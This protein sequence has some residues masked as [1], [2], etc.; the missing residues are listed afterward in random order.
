MKTRKEIYQKITEK[1]QPLKDNDTIKYIDLN[2]GQLQSPEKSFPFGFPCVLIQIDAIR[3]SHMVEDRVEGEAT[4]TLLIAYRH[5]FD[6]F[7]GSPSKSSSEDLLDLFDT[8][9]DTLGYTRGDNF[10]D[11]HLSSEQFLPYDFKGLHVHQL[12]YTATTYHQIHNHGT[13]R[14]TSGA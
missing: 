10:T 13:I 5:N 11:L 1:L 6:S 2:K 3:Y 7:V 9:I 14:I 12:T 8:I 4:I